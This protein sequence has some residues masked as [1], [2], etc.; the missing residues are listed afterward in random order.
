MKRLSNYFFGIIFIWFILSS[1]ITQKFYGETTKYATLIVF[2]AF[3]AIIIISVDKSRV[4]K[5]EMLAA[6]LTIIIS[7]ANL[8]LIG[9]NKGA[10][11]VPSDMALML[12]ALPFIPKD[13]PINKIM[14][15]A[16]AMLM[17]WWY[18]WIHW[19]Y[20]FN[21]SGLAFITFMTCGELFFEYLKRD[22][23]IDEIK[24]I[25]LLFWIVTI[26]F[27]ICYHARSAAMSCIAYGILWMIMPKVC[28][29]KFLSWLLILGSTI[30]SLLFTGLYIILGKTGIDIN[31]LYKSILSGRQDI[32]S[33]L[34]EEF[35][36]HPV[37]GIGSSYHMK[38]FFIFEVHNGML[39]ILVVHGIIVFLLV[40]Y[41][42]IKRLRERTYINRN[43]TEIERLAMAGVYTWLAASFFENGFI[44]PPY[45]VIFIALLNQSG[46]LND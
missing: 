24:Y 11:L 36:K 17:M 8:V 15:G 16:G 44:V 26:L 32:W 21:M 45:C 43:C 42:L 34:W 20:G 7:G 4:S 22:L 18:A 27:C 41:L 33:E 12:A 14:M 3:A 6:I 1:F 2:M 10:M 40:G 38:S 28:T 23:E 9:S 30:G 31:I 25:Q 5:T 13:L 19:E 35:L 39:D 29:S 37:T 46:D